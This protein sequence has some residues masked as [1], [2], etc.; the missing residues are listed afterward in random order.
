MSEEL[1]PEVDE[2]PEEDDEARYSG[3]DPTLFSSCVSFRA[4][5]IVM[6]LPFRGTRSGSPRTAL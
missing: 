5:V 1:L 3:A 6:S 2:E 4:V